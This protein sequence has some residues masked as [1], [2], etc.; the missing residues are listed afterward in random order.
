MFKKILKSTVISLS[1]LGFASVL[2]A[3]VLKFAHVY[4]VEHPLHKGAVMAAKEI[5]KNT[6]GRIDVKIYPAS[7]LGK[8]TAL[9]E[10]LTLGTVDIIHTGNGFAGSTYGPISLTS[11][12]FTLRGIEHWKNYRDSALFTDL[13][14]GY[15]KATGGMAQVVALSYYGQRQVTS[16]KPI[17]SPA[18]MKGLK[19]RVPNAP[20]FVLFPKQVGANPTPMAFAEVYLALQQGV[21]DAQENPLPTIKAK[22]FYEVQSNINLTGHITDSILTLISSH[23]L[24][25]LSKKDQSIVISALKKSAVWVTGEVLKSEAELVSWFKAKG[26][27]VNEVDRMPFIKAVAPGLKGSDMPFSKE[28]YERLQAIK[29]N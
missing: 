2:N 17:L 5:S 8:E 16:N 20:A 22:K 11:F 14:E 7:Q 19:I 25:K 10:G 18:D 27:R 13:S 23:K 12:P 28:V 24:N 1:V 9:N 4:E 6:D 15:S 21:V 29:G 3:E 26:I